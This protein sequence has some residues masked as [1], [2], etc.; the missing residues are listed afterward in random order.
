MGVSAAISLK[1][2]VTAGVFSGAVP[3]AASACSV[4]LAAAMTFPSEVS[5]KSRTIAISYDPTSTFDYQHKRHIIIRVQVHLDQQ[6]DMARR[7]Q[8]IG[9]VIPP[10]RRIATFS[11]R[12]SNCASP[13]G[14]KLSGLAV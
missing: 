6:V 12:V 9:I 11:D 10:K 4:A 13:A 5:V 1:Q 2:E 14:S 7:Q 8:T 3:S